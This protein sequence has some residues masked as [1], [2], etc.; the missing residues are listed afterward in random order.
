MVEMLKTLGGGET[1]QKL[2][3]IKT[4]M[5]ED[6]SEEIQRQRSKAGETWN[7]EHHSTPMGIWSAN[8]L[9]RK[10]KVASKMFLA[11]YS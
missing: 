4:Q 3:N 9:N 7:T 1:K 5:F 2:E 6:F 11:V 10:I 8:M